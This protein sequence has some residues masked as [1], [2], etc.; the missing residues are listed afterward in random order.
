LRQRPLFEKR[1]AITNAIPGFWPHVL[2][3]ASSTAGF[4]EY[5]TPEDAEVLT[6]VTEIKVTRPNA[7]KGD[8]RDIEVIFKIK[9]NDFMPA[10]TITKLFTHQ[11]SDKPGSTGLVSTP[12]SIIWKESKDLTFG[13]G[14]AAIEAFEERKAKAA[15]KDKKGKGS[16]KLGEKEQALHNLLSKNSA[17]FFT[18][19][20]FSGAHRELG[21]VEDESDP[22]FMDDDEDGP[23][24]PIETFPY[25][26]EFAIQFA[27]DVY[28]SAVKYF[29]TSPVHS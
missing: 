25:G 2:E 7:E 17:S 16:I 18:W 29:S 21:E 3:D 8:P 12:A 11:P 15:S 4:D 6:H 5:V 13:V 20:S 24:G 27:E 14:K 19:F 28:P 1:D 26:D 22:D 10:Q 23:A 9:E